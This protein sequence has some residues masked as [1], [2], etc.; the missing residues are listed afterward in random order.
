MEVI[1]NIAAAIETM[2]N[3]NFSFLF[4]LR[5]FSTVMTL[6]ANTRSL[7]KKAANAGANLISLKIV[8]I[9]PPYIKFKF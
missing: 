3:F 1:K 6:S 7:G 8:D 2:T 5:I 9:F 4:F